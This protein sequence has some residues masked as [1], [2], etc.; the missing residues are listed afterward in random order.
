MKLTKIEKILTCILAC[1]IVASFAVAA[2]GGFCKS[3]KKP[4]NIYATYC[5]YCAEPLFVKEKPKREPVIIP[6]EEAIIGRWK[7]LFEY[8]YEYEFFPDGTCK[9]YYCGRN[10]E[11]EPCLHPEFYEFGSG[12]GTWYFE[13]DNLVVVYSG[14]GEKAR[15]GTQCYIYE[16]NEDYTKLK[17]AGLCHDATW[18]KVPEES[19]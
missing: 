12:D 1:I 9:G 10:P 8:Y 17:I 19:E 5:N 16:F 6:H 4:N 11:Y 13:G 7:T 2:F 15:P 3:C 18:L 14:A